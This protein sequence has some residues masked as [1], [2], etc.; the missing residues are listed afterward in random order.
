MFLQP[1]SVSL[2]I[3]QIK[4]QSEQSLSE[5]QKIPIY[6]LEIKDIN[7]KFSF[8]AE[9]NKLEKS[10]LLKLPDP[11]YHETQNNYQRLKW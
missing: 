8:K 1:L 7:N 4:N 2:T 6:S 5:Y 10:I 3:K 11:N 9:I